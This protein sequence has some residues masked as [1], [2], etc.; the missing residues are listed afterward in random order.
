LSPELLTFIGQLGIGAVFLYQ[1]N[2]VYTDG[3]VERAQLIADLKAATTELQSVKDRLT[4][5]EAH[6]GIDDP[7]TLPKR[8][9]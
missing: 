8:P 1:L 5:I 7:P 4:V 3:K 6:L 9:S 2:I